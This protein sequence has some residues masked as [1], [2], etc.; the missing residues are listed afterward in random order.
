[1]FLAKAKMT[2]IVIIKELAVLSSAMRG[3]GQLHGFMM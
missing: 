1:V 2:T 3:L